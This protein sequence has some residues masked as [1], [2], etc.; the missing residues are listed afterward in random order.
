MLQVE[1][2]PW[3][4]L[5]AKLTLPGMHFYEVLFVNVVA[6]VDPRLTQYDTRGGVVALSGIDLESSVAGSLALW[7]NGS[8][9]H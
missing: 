7:R 1:M 5:S 4:T 8:V 6:D 2:A 9:R 3:D